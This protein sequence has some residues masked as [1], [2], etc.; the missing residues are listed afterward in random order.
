MV[1]GESLGIDLVPGISELQQNAGD[2]VPLLIRLLEEPSRHDSF[3]I[4]DER[5]RERNAVV[6]GGGIDGGI[7][8]PVRLDGARA[9]IRQQRECDASSP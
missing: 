4:D 1:S 7:Q 9:R 6:R 2:G 8:E 3:S 5:A